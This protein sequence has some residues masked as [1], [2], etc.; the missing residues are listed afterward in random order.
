MIRENVTTQET[1]KVEI[2]R[3]KP[4]EIIEQKQIPENEQEDNPTVSGTTN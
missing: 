4:E 1:V 2:V 3:G